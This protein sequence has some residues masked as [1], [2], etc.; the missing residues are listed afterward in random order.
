MSDYTNMFIQVIKTFL[1][2]SSVYS[3][4]FLISSASVRCLP[5]LSFV[6]HIFASNVLLVSPVFLR[7]SLVFTI[8]L[9]SSIS[10][11]CSLKKADYS[12]LK[13][14]SRNGAIPLKLVIW[15]LDWAYF[16]L[17]S[18]LTWFSPFLALRLLLS[19][20]YPTLILI[21]EKKLWDQKSKRSRYLN[22]FPIL[23]LTLGVMF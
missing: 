11:H 4:H 6:V 13:Y 9:F 5:F 1:Y 12:T 21:A 14:L 17:C 20:V 16:S 7:K 22:S 10:L 19:S 2:S 18:K 8:L 3:C 23:P 15:K